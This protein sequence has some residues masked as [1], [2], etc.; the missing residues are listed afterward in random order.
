MSDAFC[1]TLLC[2]D[3]LSDETARKL[4]DEYGAEGMKS[5]EGGTAGRGNADRLW[6][7][8]KPF[9]RENRRTK[10][11]S[12]ARCGSQTSCEFRTSHDVFCA[13]GIS[14]V[15]QRI[16]CSY[17]VL[18]CCL[19]MSLLTRKQGWDSCL[20]ESRWPRIQGYRHF[21]I[22]VTIHVEYLLLW[23][24]GVCQF[25]SI[26][27]LKHTGDRALC[28]VGQVSSLSTS[29]GCDSCCFA[30]LWSL[31]FMAVLGNI[32]WVLFVETAMIHIFVMA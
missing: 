29:G 19:S 2:T 17:A 30:W 32:T 26:A 13:H 16:S 8:F 22:V 12:A 4:Y 10:A 23:R 1:I 15:V 6:D 7:E 11:R 5:Q 20:K 24:W 9:K 31:H 28:Q 3:V 18:F 14:G 25:L 27:H 21:Q